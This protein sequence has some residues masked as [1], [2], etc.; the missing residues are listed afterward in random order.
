MKLYRLTIQGYKRIKDATVVFGD[1]T[2]IIGPNNTGKSSVLGAITH[3]LSTLKRIPEVEYYSV[4]DETTNERK[5]VS[6]K[7]VL[8]AEF[9]NL[10]AEAKAWRGFKGRVFEYNPGETGET[11]LC[12]TY[13]KTY[14]LGQDVVIELKSKSRL[15]KPHYENVSKPQELIDAGIGADLVKELY[16][17]LDKKFTAANK[18]RLEEIDD[19]WDLGTE[20]TWFQNPGGIP[21]VVLARLPR[22]IVIPADTASGEM[23]GSGVL[24]KTLNELFED[25]R[26]ASPNYKEAQ[27][28]LNELAKEMDP[29]D[30]KS[31]FG[32]MLSE[33]NSIIA[34]VFPDS[35]IHARTDLSNPDKSLKP[36]FTVELQSNI[37]T[38]VDHQGAGMVRSAVFGILRFRQKWLSRREDKDIKRSIIIGFEEP[39]MYLHPSAANQMRNTIYELSFQDSQI[40]ATTHSPYLIDLSRK[41][42]Q[43]LNRFAFSDETIQVQSFNV[44][45]AFQS[46]LNKD[47]DYVKMILKVDDYVARVFF[48]KRIVVVEGDTEDIVI[49]ETLSRLPCEKQLSIRSN[50]EIIKARGKAA[51]IGLVKYLKAMGITPIVIHD[52]DK[53]VAGAEKFNAPIIEAVGNDNVILLCECIEDV[54]GYPPPTGEKPYN[55]YT[56]TKAWGDQW[57]DVPSQWRTIV[58]KAFGIS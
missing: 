35:R 29:A 21:G 32:K 44:T 3:L 42:R 10:P 48:T 58:E 15:K 8:E 18:N 47:K 40:L 11:G 5:T 55:A 28:F 4:Q 14:E 2:F 27:K 24:P 12:L 57:E 16:D 37:R 45:D 17:D 13:R 23:S 49:R 52:R 46:L 31:E 39:E 50:T 6:N 34:R 56:F 38:P 51:I 19:I 26:D 30:T 53:D 1:A 36:T 41:P 25:V 43:A 33:L 20:D 22:Y 7:I 9:R 54:L